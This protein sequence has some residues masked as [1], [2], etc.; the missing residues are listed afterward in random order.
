MFRLQFR[1][2]PCS[3][4]ILF[5]LEIEK[6][7]ILRIKGEGVFMVSEKKFVVFTTPWELGHLGDGGRC[8]N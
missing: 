4:S 3:R 2:L 1:R 8:Q 7:V 6:Q 5:Q